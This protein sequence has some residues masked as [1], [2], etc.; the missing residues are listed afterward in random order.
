MFVDQNADLFSPLSSLLTGASTQGLL[1]TTGGSTLDLNLGS[2]SNPLDYNSISNLQN[3]Q[4][5]LQNSF[6]DIANTLQ[7]FSQVSD[8]SLHV[9]A[10]SDDGTEVTS[11]AAWQETFQVHN[12][13][14][15]DGAPVPFSTHLGL[16][17][18]LSGVVGN[19][20]NAI[21]P[22]V[23]LQFSL[24]PIQGGLS[25]LSDLIPQSGLSTLSSGFDI[26]GF[27]YGT[28][29]GFGDGIGIYTSLQNNMSYT[30]EFLLQAMAG[31]GGEADVSH[32]MNI[33]EFDVAPGTYVQ[34]ASGTDYSSMIRYVNAD[35]QYTDFNG[36]AAPEPSLAAAVL[37]ALAVMVVKAARRTA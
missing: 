30:M 25:N 22:L 23:D 20:A 14:M 12:P 13:S 33:L 36:N 9:L 8:N 32:K 24:E 11:V 5:D 18:S 19:V 21:A 15:A 37:G 29:G 17:G 6:Q 35:G 34:S 16:D 31:E 26:P 28:E 1:N 7:S 10:S 27:P 4:T 3:Q 2:T